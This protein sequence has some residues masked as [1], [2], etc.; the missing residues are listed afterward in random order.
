MWVRLKHD[1]KLFL[2]LTFVH[3]Q[4]TGLEDHGTGH[5]G[6][7]LGFIPVMTVTSQLRRAAHRWREMSDD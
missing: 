2:N 3:I 4:G 6:V 1:E 7:V 5:S